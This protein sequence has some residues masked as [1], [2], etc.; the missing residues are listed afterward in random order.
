MES[1]KPLVSIALCTFNGERFLKE[2]LDSL[3]NQSY[4]N[5]E[6]IAVDDRSTDNTL[7]ILNQYKSQHHFIKVFQNETNLGFRKN[8][9]KALS[10]ANGDYIALCDQDDVWHPDKIKIQIGNIGSNVLIYHDSS[11]IDEEGKSLNKN[12]SDI[13]NLYRGNQCHH[14]LLENCVAGHTCFFRR[15][16]LKDLLPLPT[17]LYHDKWIAFVAT[18]TGTIDYCKEALVNYRQHCT[19][20]TDILKNKK[21]KKKSGLLKIKD[22]NAEIKILKDFLP[23]DPFINKFYTL[24]V[25]RMNEY[26]SL[27][28]FLFV[29][30][31]RDVLYYIKKRSALSKFSYSVKFLWGYRLKAFFLYNKRY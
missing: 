7:S 9:E 27:E 15:S 30:Q 29:Y 22:L 21:T 2:Q 31:N 4:P 18:A 12:L 14:F 13:M 8:F 1:V 26:I 19:S 10:Y 20:T 5:L 17:L 3:I 28:L 16:L 11:F 24:L 6:I 25:R 23:D